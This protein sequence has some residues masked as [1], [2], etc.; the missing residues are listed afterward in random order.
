MWWYNLGINLYSCA[1]RAV[2]PFVRKAASWSEGRKGLFPELERAVSGSGPIVWI[3][4]ASL[5]EFEQGRPVIEAIRERYPGYRI[6]LTFFSPSGY[7]V[8]KDY[9]G[10]DWVFYLPADTPRNAERF[11]DAVAPEIA[12]FIKY[13]FWLNYLEALSRRGIP[14]YIVSAVFRR[15]SVFFRL[16]GGAF[17]R[18]LRTFRRLFVQDDESKELLAGI[19]VRQVTVAGDTRFDRVGRIAGEARRLPV[20]EDFADGRDVFVAGSTWPPDEEMLIRLADAFPD[21]KFVIAP[22]EMDEKRIGA[23]AASVKGGAVRYTSYG[24]AD[25][26]K[27]KQLLIVDTIGILSSVYGYGRYAYVGG[28]FG[29]GIHNTLEAAVFGMPVAFGPNYGKFR[30]AHDLIAAGAARSVSGYEELEAWLSGLRTDRKAYGR[31]AAA[32]GTYVRSHRGATDIILREIFAGR[33]GN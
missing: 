7:E 23:L 11:L 32:A 26:G 31:A 19:G 12:V 4:A 29:A 8:R 28:G 15:D 2:S 24:A 6:L 21:M 18:A 14:T 25:D 16:W 1:V 9:R 22:H 5:G 3:H 20:V 17:R 27:D 33:K 13:E 30:E 10:A